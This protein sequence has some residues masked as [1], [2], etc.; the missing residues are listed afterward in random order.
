MPEGVVYE[1]LLGLCWC[2]IIEARQSGLGRGMELQHRRSHEEL[3]CDRGTVMA[4]KTLKFVG[5]CW[6][7]AV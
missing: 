3:Q 6:R 5:C 1:E 4:I 7:I 2:E